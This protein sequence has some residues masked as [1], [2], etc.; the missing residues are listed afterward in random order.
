[1]ASSG[2]LKSGPQT[3]VVYDSLLVRHVALVPEEEAVEV[4]ERILAI[5][6]QL[7]EDGLL[8]Q[9]QRIAIRPVSEAEI[10]AIHSPSYL[11]HFRQLGEIGL[12]MRGLEDP[13]TAASDSKVEEKQSA[14]PPTS[15]PTAPPKPKLLKRKVH[16]KEASATTETKTPTVALPLHTP[17]SLLDDLSNWAKAYDSVG[18]GKYSKE[19]AELAA[20]GVC[21]LTEAVLRG[22]IRNGACFVRPP[23]HHADRDHAAGFCFLNNVPIAAQMA[24]DKYKLN[25]ILIVDWDVH[26]G[27]G[28]SRIFYDDPRFLVFSVHLHLKGKFWPHSQFAEHDNVG[29]GKGKGYNVNVAWNHKKMG[30]AEYLSCWHNL[31]LPL[32]Y[33]YQ[34][35]L[36]FISAGFDSAKGDLLGHCE[37]T[38]TGYAHLTHLLMGVTGGKIVLVLEG[39]YNCSVIAE[40]SSAC[41]RVL[42]GQNP[43][44]F[45]K[46]AAVRPEGSEAIWTTRNTLALYW[47]NLH[48]SHGLPP[49]YSCRARTKGGQ[50]PDPYEADD[51][52]DPTEYIRTDPSLPKPS[53]TKRVT[54]EGRAKKQSHGPPPSHS[55]VDK[56]RRHPTPSSSSAQD[57]QLEQAMQ[58]LQV[59]E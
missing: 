46:L 37:V 3:G 54:S 20:G 23:G 38:P 57:Q 56:V 47:K 40:C 45:E 31:L 17:A 8:D 58:R 16:K 25:R 24:A 42:L 52:E 7:Q 34:P 19:C 35:Q 33:Q 11:E 44:P 1:M 22:E 26:H 48:I 49:F 39:G 15:T 53:T 27:D 30:D 28:T 14:S 41:L 29:E 10:K 51:G 5:W 32:A 36:I 43:P 6:K 12:K 21:A 50:E 4:P 55:A 59:K 2:S 9:C 13:Q 18:V